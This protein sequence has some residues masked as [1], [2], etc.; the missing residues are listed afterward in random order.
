M[1]QTRRYSVKF[2]YSPELLLRVVGACWRRRLSV[3][4][5]DFQI[6]ADGQVGHLVL[7][8]IADDVEERR[9]TSWLGNLID[10]EEIH[11]LGGPAQRTGGTGGEQSLSA[12]ARRR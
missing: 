10:V 4:A 11:Y 9:L 12:L 6:P 5:V 8:V 2:R 3:V 7:S 1:P